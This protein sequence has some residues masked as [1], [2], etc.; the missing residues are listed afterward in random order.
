MERTGVGITADTTLPDVIL[1]QGITVSGSVQDSDL[2][3]VPGVDLNFV[4]SLSGVQI[5]T[6]RDNSDAAGAFAVV[7]P[8]DLYDIAFR[9][10]VGSTLA[11]KRLEAV[12]LPVNTTLPAVTLNQGFI[13]SGL[14]KDSAGTGLEN[15]DLDF[16]DSATKQLVFTI[17]D[18][19]DLAGNYAVVVEPGTYNIQFIPPP[20]STFVAERLADVAVAGDLALPE[21]VLPA[22][23]AVTGRV[24]SSL[25]AGIA[26]IDLDFF[27][28]A[29]DLGVFTPRDI[30]GTDGSFRVVVGAGT[31]N[32]HF[33]PPAGGR[34][35]GVRLADV[36]LPADTLLP[37]VVMGEG[38]LVSGGVFDGLG[39]PV[40]GVDLEFFD[41]VT[42][43][44][45]FTAN[46]DTGASGLYSVP[47]PAG[48]YTI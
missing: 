34:L 30:S 37:D 42:N 32:I 5:Y 31:Y 36:A 8:P 25:G 26:G 29:T 7:V 15:V 14:V 41:S 47:V 13:V 23:V 9:P 4:D 44:K 27:D 12:N 3:P 38:F 6:I 10:S 35:L 20:A 17:R 28:D 39:A 22:G 16:F 11:P 2:Q 33:I 21:V 1:P 46:D 18:H 43:A 19:T 40:P 48:T 45:V 24:I